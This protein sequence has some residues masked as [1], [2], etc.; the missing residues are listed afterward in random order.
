MLFRSH[1]NRVAE[2]V[3]QYVQ[4][5][6]NAVEGLLRMAPRDPSGRPI[7]ASLAAQL[8]A[9]NNAT[10]YLVFFDRWGFVS[11]S[12]SSDM[13][14]AALSWLATKAARLGKTQ[15]ESIGDG[16]NLAFAAPDVSEGAG[17]LVV[18][19]SGAWMRAEVAEHASSSPL[20]FELRD[21]AGE[22]LADVAAQSGSGVAL[23]YKARQE[24]LLRT[25]RIVTVEGYAIAAALRLDSVDWE[26]FAVENVKES[27]RY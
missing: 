8:E 16:G 7:V 3:D 12:G 14:S 27:S 26:L 10:V 15:V 18:V 11:E 22:V 2:I 13:P 5:Q 20:A 21:S 9:V 25:G 24:A 19:V 6:R 17:T 4:Y 1:L 23:A